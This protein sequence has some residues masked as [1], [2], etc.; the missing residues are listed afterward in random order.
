MPTDDLADRI[1]AFLDSQHV[2]SL[3]TQ[4]ADGVH[5]ANL[6]YTRDRFALIWVSDPATRHSQHL[7]APAMVAVTIAPD[8]TDFPSVKGL[9]LAGT[10]QLVTD[11]QADRAARARLAARY[12]FLG[13]IDALPEKVREAYAGARIYRFEPQRIVLIDNSRGF[14]SKE[15]LE[16]GTSGKSW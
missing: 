4:G 3:A 14:G 9:Q 12:P 11:P 1:T 13:R 5:A 16:L 10:A 8:Y 2:L 15:V 6:F 7:A